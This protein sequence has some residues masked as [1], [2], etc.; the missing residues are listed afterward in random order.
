MDTY[1]KTDRQMSCDV[2][3]LSVE[4]RIDLREIML[5]DMSSSNWEF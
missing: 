5:F 1:R 4:I 2:W 3:V